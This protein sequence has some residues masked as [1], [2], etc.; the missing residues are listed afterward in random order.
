[1]T[2]LKPPRW[3]GTKDQRVVQPD[4][5]LEG[6]MRAGLVPVT[7]K[8]TA[9]MTPFLAGMRSPGPNE[10]R[11]SAVPSSNNTEY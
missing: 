11:A 4:A 9:A 10:P 1:M 6:V 2:K 5:L 7:E 8:A 3:F